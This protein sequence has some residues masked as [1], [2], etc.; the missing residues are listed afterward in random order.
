MTNMIEILKAE[1][2]LASDFVPNVSG[3]VAD[4]LGSND[5]ILPN[6]CFVTELAVV[7][8]QDEPCIRLSLLSHENGIV[9]SGYIY[10]R[11]VTLADLASCITKTTM[12]SPDA[13]AI[14]FGENTF[15]SNLSHIHTLSKKHALV[16]NDTQLD[17]WSANQ[18]K[19]DLADATFQLYTRMARV[20]EW[21]ENNTPIAC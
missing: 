17:A 15:Y 4:V 1:N 16:G 8:H 18:V 11:N 7:Q 12:T 19:S 14:V 2:I 13:C 9:S 6:I 10:I 5:A 21:A 3:A 20:L